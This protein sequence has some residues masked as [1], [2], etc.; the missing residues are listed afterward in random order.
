MTATIASRAGGAAL[1]RVA[2]TF[3][4]HVL[5]VDAGASLALELRRLELPG[6][7]LSVEV[8]HKQYYPTELVG[9]PPVQL[10]AS[11]EAMQTAKA[12]AGVAKARASLGDI[13]A[14]RVAER[15]R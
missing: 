11:V 9:L 3:C 15:R 13:S 8:A 10:V 6:Y 7:I 2:A 5:S 14:M 12:D 1:P 4:Q